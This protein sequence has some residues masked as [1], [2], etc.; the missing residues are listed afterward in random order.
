[1]KNW[2]RDKV[3]IVALERLSFQFGG[4][5][6]D[7]CNEPSPT[8]TLSLLSPV[9]GPSQPPNDSSK[10]GPH[11]PLNIAVALVVIPPLLTPYD[12]NVYL[13]TLR[14]RGNPLCESLGA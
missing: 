2:E 5:E 6:R 13:Q 12:E 7:D 3:G 14:K 11:R 4:P 10:E 1:M 9:P 8:K